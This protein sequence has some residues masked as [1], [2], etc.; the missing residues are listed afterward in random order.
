MHITL[1][2]D[3]AIRII[4]FLLQHKDRAD[5]KKISENTGVTLRF[6]LKILRKL[7]GAGLVRSYK[8]ATGGYEAAREPEEISLADV[9]EVTEGTYC[10]SRCLEATASCAH[11]G[12]GCCKVRQVFGEISDTVRKK[13]EQTT[14][15]QL[16]CS[17]QCTH[18]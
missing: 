4:L 9:M 17:D 13:L 7:V 2:S 6:S 16:I 5:A 18:S 12:T 1:E 11:D 8:G 14:F 3:Y 10:L 15:D